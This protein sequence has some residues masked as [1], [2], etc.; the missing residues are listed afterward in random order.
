MVS[1]LGL[2]KFAQDQ[3]SQ[4]HHTF[5]LFLITDDVVP[6]RL[7]LRLQEGF[8]SH[9]FHGE[10]IG[11]G[12]GVKKTVFS[13]VR[14]G[15]PFCSETVVLCSCGSDQFFA[16]DAES[17]IDDFCEEGVV[18]GCCASCENNQVILEYS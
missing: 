13:F 11:E 4:G 7:T 10:I 15:V 1:L 12:S 2:E 17:F 5:R 3:L 18:V 16:G 14:D 8:H 9:D 6:L